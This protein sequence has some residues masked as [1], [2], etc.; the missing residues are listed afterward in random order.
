MVL[1]WL[2]RSRTVFAYAQNS[3]RLARYSRIV[4]YITAYE[5]DCVSHHSI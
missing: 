1:G 3:N 5:Q 2:G 4:F